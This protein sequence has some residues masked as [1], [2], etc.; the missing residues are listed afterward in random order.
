M[1]SQP[2]CCKNRTLPPTVTGTTLLRES[3]ASWSPGRVRE[4]RARDSWLEDEGV[5]NSRFDNE[6]GKGFATGV[7][8][9][10]IDIDKEL[11]LAKV[12]L[13]SDLL[14]TED[15][16]KIE[17]DRLLEESKCHEMEHE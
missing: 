8:R 13:R 1:Q 16:V 6:S 7:T 9:L 17:F 3:S 12:V 5:P 11:P 2:R 14:A 15:S 10:E 4:R